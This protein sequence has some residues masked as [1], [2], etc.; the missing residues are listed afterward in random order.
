MRNE[1]EKKR[2][3]KNEHS[4]HETPSGLCIAGVLEGE[5]R[6]LSEEKT[7]KFSTKFDENYKFIDP[8]SSTSSRTRKL[9]QSISIILNQ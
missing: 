5:E 6:A 4:I 3:E 2:L 7:A 1:T 9:H 8:R